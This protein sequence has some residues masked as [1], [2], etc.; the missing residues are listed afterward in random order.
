MHYIKI[1]ILSAL[2]LLLPTILHAGT[3]RV[4]PSIPLSMQ[5]RKENS[6]FVISKMI[7]LKNDT[8]IVPQNSKLKF[9]KNGCLKNGTIY[10]NNSVIEG[11]SRLCFSNVHF[12]GSFKI[13]NIQALA[14]GNY[15]N[16]TELL[17][18]MLDLLFMSNTESTLMLDAGRV[19]DVDY[20][21]LPYAHAIYEYYGKTNKSII[22][23]GT[24]IND[25]RTRSEIGYKSY[26]GVFLFS[27]CHNI[28]IKGL[29]YQNLNEDFCEIR[30]GDHVVFKEG[31]ENQ[32]GYVGTSFILLQ[33]DC[34]NIE[35]EANIIGARYGVKSGD[36]SQFWLCGNYGIKQSTIK[37]NAKRTGYPVAIEVGDSLDIIVHSE[38]HHRAAYI[39]GLSNSNI[40]IEA[41]DIYIAPLHCLLSD[42]HYSKGDR[43]HAKYKAC[44]F[45]NVKVVELGSTVAT[46]GDCYCVGLQTY[47]TI[48]F[49]NR[50]E[51]L[52]WNNISINV[53]KKAPAT[54][55]G[56]FTLSRNN[57]SS[58]TD[59]LRIEDVFENISLMAEDPFDTEQYALRIR[60][61]EFG[62]YNKITLSI[63]A[64]HSSIIVDNRNDYVFD[65]ETLNVSNSYYFGKVRLNKN[66][67]VREM[68]STMK[69]E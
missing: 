39:C 43:T 25:L 35:I 42:T 38:E 41:K 24:T 26:D 12:D 50:N 46:N 32:I 49:Y 57:P 22:G 8:I 69:Y 66:H 11:L 68:K 2:L 40:N 59:P 6:T 56:L 31:F 27:G 18:A 53:A 62:K 58:P 16:D 1:Y 10:G 20:E 37:I 21:K 47:N 36:Y 9:R 28:S 30:E 19:Y 14:F 65:L 64:P 7:D 17:R 5:L 34:S 3:Y 52:T 60:V 48:P 54:K 63:N 55:V 45:L 44:S 29:N 67:N 4:S 23:L 13:S 51:P 61:N 15:P 33:D